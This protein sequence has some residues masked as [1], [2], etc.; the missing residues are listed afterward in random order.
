MGGIS[1]HHLF[2]FSMPVEFYDIGFHPVI[3]GDED[4]SNPSS[5]DVSSRPVRGG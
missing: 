3:V 4:V 5:A 2:A 1:H